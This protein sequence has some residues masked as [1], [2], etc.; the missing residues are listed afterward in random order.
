[1]IES[2]KEIIRQTTKADHMIKQVKTN[3]LAVYQVIIRGTVVS[4]HLS[5]AAA[6]TKVLRILN[7]LNKG[8]L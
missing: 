4:T 6:K 3:G 1:M 8:G 2:R 7:S 5:Q